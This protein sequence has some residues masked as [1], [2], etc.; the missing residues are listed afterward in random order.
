VF[1]DLGGRAVQVQDDD[2][3]ITCHIPP[4][5]KGHYYNMS[6]DFDS[7]EKV[8]RDEMAITDW[9]QECES[10]IPEENY[11]R[12][13]RP[14][15]DIKGKLRNEKLKQI[16]NPAHIDHE[17]EDY[18]Q[19]EWNRRELGVWFRN[20]N[21]ETQEVDDEYI[22]GAHY[23]YLTHWPLDTGYPDFRKADQ[24]YFYFIKHVEMNT[25][26]T[27]MIEAT[28]RRG[29]K[30]YRGGMFVWDYCSRNERVHG[31]V[32]S[33]TERDAKVNVFRKAVVEPYRK[34]VQTFKPIYDQS[35]GE[36][37]TME[38]SFFNTNKKGEVL[39]NQEKALESWVDWASS[40]PISYDGHKLHRYLH[41]ECFK[42]K[43]SVYDLYEVVAPCLDDGNGNII[44]KCLF[45]STVEEMNDAA[46]E[47]NVK[48]W[49]DSDQ[50][51][52]DE[53]GATTTGLYR[54]FISALLT[55]NVDKYGYAPVEENRKFYQVKRDKLRDDPRKLAA[56]KRKYPFTWQ[57]AFA[58][59]A[60]QCLYDIIRLGDR[61]ERLREIGDRAFVRGKLKWKDE[62]DWSK[63][64]DFIPRVN[65]HFYLAY[66]FP[67]DEI[68][69]V[70]R[71]GTNIVPL[72]PKWGAI[73]IDPYDHDD[74]KFGGGS[75]GAG[76]AYRKHRV[77]DMDDD[78]YS[79]NL[80]MIYLG[81]PPFAKMLFEDMAK[82][83]IFTGYR[84]L[85]EDNKPGVKT[86]FKEHDMEEFMIR[87]PGQKEPGISGSTKTH[88]LIVERT[89]EYVMRS[90]FKCM[91]AKLVNDLIRFDILKTTKFDLAM[92]LGYALIAI[93][94]MRIATKAQ[95]KIDYDEGSNKVVRKFAL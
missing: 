68:N 13:P 21:P 1:R 12:R 23:L 51:D 11:W 30:T 63:G 32:Q 74:V 35:K 41:D 46:M 75:L 81:R 92:A 78:L 61:E 10:A 4:V 85:F 15:V 70:K 54:F 39:E 28:R 59:N 8:V 2:L 3:A 60:G 42:R 7:G 95:N 20:Y 44:G 57:E 43:D 72:N 26:C 87:I 83:C 53:F 52:L 80:P 34:I 25:S 65:G 67:V 33:K 5:G 86:F 37:P 38:L 29:G 27:G 9:I 66:N 69:Q 90:I 62:N 71:R 56:Y 50:S 45:T 82:F 91:F 24:D 18:R 58:T 84:M 14:P 64:C 47:E 77:G 40:D 73:G 49:N 55:R 76:V 19:Q 48:L 79:N 94:I 6:Y 22:T 93:E 36:R 16:A 17:L 88:Q 31:G 89:E